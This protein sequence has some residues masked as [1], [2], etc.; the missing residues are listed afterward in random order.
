MMARQCSL[1]IAAL[2]CIPILAWAGNIGAA[3]DKPAASS[4]FVLDNGLQVFLQEK[5]DLPLTAM[6]LAIDL[7]SKD[8]T[9]QTSGYAHLLEHMLL[10]GAS[11]GMDGETRLAELRR[12]GIEHNA[13][14]DHDLIT[15]EVSCP[16]ADS[17]WALESLRQTVFFSRLD[18]QQLESEK[19]IILEEI[20]QLRGNPLSLGRMLVMQQLFAGHPYGQPVYG[21]GSAIK[22]ATVEPLLAFYKRLLI[23]GRCA[24][25][26]VGDF[27]LAEVEKEIRRNWGALPKGAAGAAVIPPAGRLEK[28]SE[29]Q[30]ELDINESH[31]FFAWWAPD[32]N[33]EQR[34]P[35]TVL[36]YI[37]GRGLNPLLN[38]VLLGGRQP[39]DQL[40]MG[41]MP[42]RSGGM[43]VLHLTL[44]E[45]NMRYAKN[46]LSR[47]LSQLGTFNFGREDFQQPYQQYVLDFLESAKNQ[48]AYDTENFRESTLNLSMAVARF[49][50]L[51]TVKGSN[52]YL[53]NVG[54]I[55]SS[56]LRRVAGKYLSGKK[57]AV[58]AIVPRAGKAK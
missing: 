22:T 1:L 43:V 27:A 3:A 51:N 5:H 10:F 52:S 42:L 45:K 35:L 41:Y 13:H 25:A 37:L 21:D 44:Q 16:A 23:P 38:G 8:E 4:Y 19:R 18:P 36:T 24:L 56:D 48:M 40:D 29:Q 49:L 31:L 17:G 15:F 28:S 47:F 11:A 58:L 46:T 32:F 50:L 7:G 14:T 34:I 9:E 53:E 2:A 20:L 39:A 55:T 6:T 26:I 30:I 12:H 54:K 57:W 33:N